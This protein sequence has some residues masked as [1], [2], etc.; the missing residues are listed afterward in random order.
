MYNL[1]KYKGDVDYILYENECDGYDDLSLSLRSIYKE[2]FDCQLY[3]TWPNNQLVPR[4]YE[5]F[6]FWGYNYMTQPSNIHG[7]NLGLFIAQPCYLGSKHRKNSQKTTRILMSYYSMSYCNGE[8]RMLAEYKH[9]MS[10]Y[11]LN[12]HIYT[13]SLQLE[14]GK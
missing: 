7:A 1:I 9:N 3:C 8:W 2:T 4:V 6:Q 12:L 13:H 14:G 11:G 5:V 10:A